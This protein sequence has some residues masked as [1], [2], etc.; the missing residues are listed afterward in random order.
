MNAQFTTPIV[1]TRNVNL[2][3]D[4]KM[5]RHFYE[6]LGFTEK[7]INSFKD[8]FGKKMKVLSYGEGNPNAG[9]LTRLTEDE[10]KEAVNQVNEY[11]K[12]I[13]PSI[14]IIPVELR[15]DSLLPIGLE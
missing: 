5:E 14:E 4:C 9:I 10:Y 12:V 7:E 6:V 13:E 3:E 8:Q 15:A 2:K 1:K 11:N